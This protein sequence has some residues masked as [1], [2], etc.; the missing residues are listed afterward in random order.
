RSLSAGR[1]GPAQPPVG[2]PIQVSRRFLRTPRSTNRIGSSGH[3]RQRRGE[4]DESQGR[5]SGT[6]RNDHFSLLSP[7]PL[8]PLYY[9]TSRPSC[10]PPLQ[11]LP[12]R[13]RYFH[14]FWP[15]GLYDGASE[16]SEHRV[17]QTDRS[18]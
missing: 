10:Y 14:C 6:Q 13:V 12:S 3:A 2:P 1:S 5:Q 18:K 4:E 15:A 8:P 7:W 17:V 16:S 9:V 11:P